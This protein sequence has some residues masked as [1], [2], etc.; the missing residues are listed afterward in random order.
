MPPLKPQFTYMY[1]YKKMLLKKAL[2]MSPFY[3][4]RKD[5]HLCKVLTWWRSYPVTYN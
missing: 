3:I 4:H 2:A 5:L 1:L